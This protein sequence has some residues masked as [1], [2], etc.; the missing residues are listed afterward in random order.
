MSF[1]PHAFCLAT[2]LAGPLAAALPG[3]WT[4]FP[5]VPVLASRFRQESDSAV[6]G[7]MA[8]EGNLLLA[9]GG[10]LKVTY[11]TGLT[12]TSDGRHLVQYDPDTRTAQRVELARAVRDFPLL[13]ILLDPARIGTL[14][15]AESAGGEAVKLVP[16]APD[17]PAL[18][19][20]GRKG[21]LHT[22]EWTDPTGARQR[23]ELLDPKT[24]PS[25]GP[26]AFKAQVPPGTRWA[27][28]NG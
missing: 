26:A 14:Y 3:W 17:I 11:D 12:V 24:P 16:R 15:R 8:R 22:L 21:L 9:R 13:G 1:R 10:K 19:A 23:L 2:L 4:A 27:T 25:P 6:F 20:T 5:K 7:K 18:T 28:P